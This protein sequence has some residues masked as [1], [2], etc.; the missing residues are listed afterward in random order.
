MVVFVDERV[1]LVLEFL[2]ANDVTVQWKEKSMVGVVQGA[3]VEA[4]GSNIAGPCSIWGR[5]W[6]EFVH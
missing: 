6:N 5:L 4:A 3:V 2:E 1:D